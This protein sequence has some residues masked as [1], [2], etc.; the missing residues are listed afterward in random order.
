[1]CFDWSTKLMCFHNAMEH[2]NDMNDIIGCLQ[3]VKIY[4]FMK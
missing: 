2:K 3:L 1:M 4:S